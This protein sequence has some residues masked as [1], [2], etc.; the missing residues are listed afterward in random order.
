MEEKKNDLLV[1]QID[2]IVLQS[3]NHILNFRL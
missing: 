3:I 2:K 1:D